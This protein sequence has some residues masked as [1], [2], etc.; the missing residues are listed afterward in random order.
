[1]MIPLLC[2]LALF[3][4]LSLALPVQK[5]FDS[6]A[7]DEIDL[8]PYVISSSHI[9]SYMLSNS[10]TDYYESIVDQVMESSMTDIIRSAPHSYKLFYPDHVTDCKASVCPFMHALSDHLNLMK[11]NLV[12][13]V[14]PLVDANLPTLPLKMTPA[15]A[16]S[17]NVDFVKVAT[18]L[19]EALNVLNQRM[20]LHLGLIINANEAADIIIRQSVPLP[21]SEQP[22]ENDTKA[23]KAMTEWLHLWLMEIEGV[24]YSQF[25]ERIQDITQSI[26]EDVLIEE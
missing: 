18:Q 2:F 4:T 3:S 9:N 11:S 5:V 25:D 22:S 24:F 20:A 14:R 1:M 8:T 21:N 23:T 19:S 26:L 7:S 6:A 13:S 12:A 16:N 10:L 17:K 15:K